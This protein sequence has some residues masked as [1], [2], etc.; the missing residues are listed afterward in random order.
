[1]YTFSEDME[2]QLSDIRQLLGK[3][4]GKSQAYGDDLSDVNPAHVWDFDKN[5][6]RLKMLESDWEPLITRAQGVRQN[7]MQDINIDSMRAAGELKNGDTIL[8]RRTIDTNLRR[9]HAPYMQFVSGPRRAIV[10]TCVSSSDVQPEMLERDY[11]TMARYE[12]YEQAWFR[13][14]DGAQLHG[15]A[16]MLTL[17]DPKMPGAFKHKYIAYD[18]LIFPIRATSLQ[19]CEYIVLF[20]DVTLSQLKS[21]I[22]ENGFDEYQVQCVMQSMNRSLYEDTECDDIVSLRLCMYKMGGFVYSTWYHP[23]C[24]NWLRKP[25]P[26]FLGKRVLQQGVEDTAFGPMHRPMQQY[27]QSLPEN[28]VDV[29]ET[30]YPVDLYVA[31]DSEEEQITLHRGRGLYDLQ[32]QQAQTSIWSSFVNHLRKSADMY[33][34]PAN[35]KSPGEPSILKKVQLIPGSFYDKKMEWWNMPAPS[36]IGIV[37]SQALSTESSNDTLQPAFTVM[38]RKDARKT[39]K[40]MQVAEQAQAQSTSVPLTLFATV[41]RSIHTR[42]FDIVMSRAR[43][44]KLEAFLPLNAKDPQAQ[45]EQADRRKFLL[46]QTYLLKSGGEV[47]I[48]ERAEKLEQLQQFFPVIANSPLRNF[49][50]ARM[51]EIAFPTEAE[52]MKKIIETAMPEQALTNSA[53]AL[54]S[55]IVQKYG[56][57]M[58]P[59][60]LQAITQ[61]IQSAQQSRQVSK[62]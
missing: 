47:E 6:A 48:L 23:Q 13:L 9:L 41:Y 2:R 5:I 35:D 55:G 40:E 56:N 4:N 24:S 31:Y 51:V 45:Q 16:S 49:F 8:P 32:M 27:E 19:K 58:A 34:S 11:T 33:A 37:A 3:T 17:F 57:S 10:L 50:L 54:L 1:M 60:E 7:R 62:P 14:I 21:F 22:K 53:V 36:N 29:R 28:W 15:W 44:G 59:E 52:R 18:K 25:K 42:S 39:K 20:I 43:Q 30:E 61:I 46:E 12:E 26:L 38:N